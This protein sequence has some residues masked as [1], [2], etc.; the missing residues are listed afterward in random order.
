MLVETLLEIVILEILSPK[1]F[2]FLRVPLLIE[3]DFVALHVLSEAWK[4]R[5]FRM[6]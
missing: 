6:A 4:K 1:S 2:F 5:L 3:K